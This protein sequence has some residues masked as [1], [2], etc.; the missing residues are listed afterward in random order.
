L[1]EVRIGQ[2]RA[3]CVDCRRA[4]TQEQMPCAMMHEDGLLL[5][6]LGWHEA[7]VRPCDCLADRLSVCCVVL[8]ALYG[9]K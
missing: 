4:L 7:H 5:G 6:G 3:D 1:A 9:L 2:M 8:L